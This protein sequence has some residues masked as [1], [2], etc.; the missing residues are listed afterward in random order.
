MKIVK[1]TCTWIASD[2]SPAGRPMSIEMNTR[3]NLTTPSMNPTAAMYLHA[4][5]G[6]LMKNTAGIAT[7]VKRSAENSRG[8]KWSSPTWMAT[9]FTPQMNATRT[10]SAVE[11]AG[12][13]C[14]L[15][16]R[17]RKSE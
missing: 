6:R 15:G 11:R 4:T 5:G 16:Q 17:T 10:R 13:P 9:K 8:G 2:A 3:P 14:M 12:M 1:S 7:S